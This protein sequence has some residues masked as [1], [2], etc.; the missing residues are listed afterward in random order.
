MWYY[1]KAFKFLTKIFVKKKTILEWQL[2][3]VCTSQDLTFSSVGFITLLLAIHQYTQALYWYKG[4]RWPTNYTAFAVTLCIRECNSWSII[5][6]LRLEYIGVRLT[7]DMAEDYTYDF[8][9]RKKSE[10]LRQWYTE[11]QVTDDA[12]LS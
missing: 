12:H 1:R 6:V 11:L 8:L 5:P 2:Q 3:N 9:I 4:P 10:V 7:Y